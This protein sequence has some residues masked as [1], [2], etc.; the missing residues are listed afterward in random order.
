[1]ICALVP[2][3][4]LESVRINVVYPDDADPLITAY[5]SGTGVTELH[6]PLVSV[7]FNLKAVS[8]SYLP[9]TRMYKSP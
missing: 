4:R 1:M 9:T 5:P 3:S 2:V 7:T 8:R 6:S